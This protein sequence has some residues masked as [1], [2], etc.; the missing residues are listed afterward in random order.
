MFSALSHILVFLFVRV[1]Y[2]LGG[3]FICLAIFFLFS[4]KLITLVMLDTPEF[5]VVI[6]LAAT[7]GGVL[8]A[9][10]GP[11]LYQRHIMRGR[12][13]LLQIKEASNFHGRHRLK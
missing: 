13:S 12:G 5:G 6:L 10:F 9:L 8:C 4:S 7:L 3:T 2:F 11:P 1:I